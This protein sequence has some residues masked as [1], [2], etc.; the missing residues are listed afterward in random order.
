VTLTPAGAGALQRLTQAGLDRFALF[1][2]DWEPGEVQTLAALLDKLR[3]SM[4]AVGEREQPPPA[5]RE[6]PRA[7]DRHRRAERHDTERQA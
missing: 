2:A 1:V 6:R 5:R 3:T 7:A 4:A